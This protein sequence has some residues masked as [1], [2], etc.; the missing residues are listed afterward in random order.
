MVGR[1]ANRASSNEERKSPGR[2]WPDWY[3]ELATF[4]NSDSRKAF[5]QLINTLVPYCCLWYLMI[6]S[7]QIGYPFTL[8]LILILPAAAFLVRIFILFH[9]CVH[10]SFFKSMSANTFLGYLL[11]V[12]VFTSFEDWR[13]SHLR[14][15]A[16]YANLDARGFGDIWTMTRS[17]YEDLPKRKQL[18]YRLYRNPVVLIGL[19]VIFN[20]LLGNRLPTRR[21][22]RKERMSVLFTNLL[23]IA[24]FLVA[25]RVIGWRIYL[26]I[27]L[28]V[29]LLAG[30]AGIWL[31]YVQH[32]FEGGYWARKSEWE[33]LRAAMEGSSFYKLP[34]VLR[35]LSSNIG[36]HH[37]HHLSPRIPNYHLKKCYDSVPALQART[38]LTIV[39]SLSCFRL[40]LWDEERQKMVAFP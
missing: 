29:L 26:L 9:D 32:Q 12:L 2:L 6:R 5:W 23:I 31:F 30:A 4:R 3:P 18:Q 21:V 20:F 28:P 33:P 16:T 1:E 19:G 7:I 13:F 11:G 34:A 40:K 24:V 10:G 38:P 37:V 39:K 15:H 22:K 25:A 14:H 36:Y 17:E 8:T 35:W 27:Q